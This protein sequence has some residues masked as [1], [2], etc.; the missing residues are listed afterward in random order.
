MKKL[1]LM[2][3]LALVMAAP[4]F[5]ADETYKS[6][7][8]MERDENGNYVSET[9]EKLKNADGSTEKAV[10][11]EDVDVKADGTVK[12]ETK[13]TEI[14]DPKGLMNKQKVKNEKT[15]VSDGEGNFEEKVVKETKDADGTDKKLKSSTNIEKDED[16]LEKS[17]VKS[18][19]VTD[20]KGLFNKKTEKTKV[21]TEE[22]ADGTVEM[23][24]E[25]VVDG[26]KVEDTEIVQ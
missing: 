22:K 16:G 20:P 21:T 17:E 5:A 1:Y 24:R 11:K 2:T 25:K 15:S 14:T 9:K 10:V 3:A 7:T 8:T 26:K 23:N 6:E 12:V 18:K 4:A 19:K 13:S